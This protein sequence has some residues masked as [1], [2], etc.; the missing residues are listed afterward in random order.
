MNRRE[1]EENVAAL[2]E[3]FDKATVAIIAETKG[4]DVAAVQKLR[5]AVKEV[6]GEYKIAK[7]SLAK[8]A[9]EETAYERLCEKLE[10]PS[11]IVFGYDDPVSV[12]KVLVDFAE[13]NEVVAVRV[14]VLDEEVLDAAA[15]DALAKLP[16]KEALLAQLLSL[17]QAPA[18][19]LLR[20]INE[21][22]GQLARL[23]EAL[24]SKLE[25]S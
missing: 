21:P 2:R 23:V 10:G 1:K 5:R 11:G 16:S 3:R 18:T 9:L 15:I 17:M 25:T 7:N 13:E 12:T 22:A 8:R 6:G 14:G 24:R 20:T 4:L 19:Q